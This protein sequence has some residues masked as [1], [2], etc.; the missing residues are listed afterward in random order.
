MEGQP[1]FLVR[2]EY[3]SDRSEKRSTILVFDSLPP[4]LAQYIINIHKLWM[5]GIRHAVV[6][7]KDDIHNLS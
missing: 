6:A 3:Q 5:T 1:K 2:F 4:I 7:H